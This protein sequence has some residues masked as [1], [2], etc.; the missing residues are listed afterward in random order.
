MANI[1]P[2][3]TGDLLAEAQREKVNA[4]VYFGPAL[5]SKYSFTLPE[6]VPEEVATVVEVERVDKPSQKLVCFLGPFRLNGVKETNRHF[7]GMQNSSIRINWPML[8]SSFLECHPGLG[9]RVVFIGISTAWSYKVRKLQTR[10]R[11][12]VTWKRLIHHVEF[13]EEEGG[14]KEMYLLFNLQFETAEDVNEFI[15]QWTLKYNDTALFTALLQYFDGLSIPATDSGPAPETAAATLQNH[16]QSPDDTPVD[17]LA[18]GMEAFLARRRPTGPP[19][20]G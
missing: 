14:T 16:T 11:I 12:R 4:D 20:A 19:A 1:P 18:P 13:Q 7:V 2:R 9:D 15:H 5:V 10:D 17:M 8:L 3:L 6:G